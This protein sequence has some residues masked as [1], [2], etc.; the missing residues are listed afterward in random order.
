MHVAFLSVNKGTHSSDLRSDRRVTHFL[1]QPIIESDQLKY[2]LYY[3][4]GF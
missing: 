4:Q 1:V 3:L 2:Y